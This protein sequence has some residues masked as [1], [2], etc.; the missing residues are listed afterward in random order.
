MTDIAN[1]PSPSS[2][3]VG[4]AAEL[5]RPT[6]VSGRRKMMVAG[7]VLVVLA[8]AGWAMAGFYGDRLSPL[9]R[10]G[11]RFPDLSARETD[12]A[13]EEELTS[14][15][16]ALTRRYTDEGLLIEAT[17]NTQ[18]LFA[19]L[20]RYQ[21]TRQPSAKADSLFERTQRVHEMDRYIVFTL[22][23]GGDAFALEDLRPDE[24]IRLRTPSGREVST[25][26]WTEVPTS[27]PDHS[28]IG[29]LH[30][31][32]VTSDGQPLIAEGDAWLEM[33][34]VALGTDEQVLRWELPIVYPSPPSAAKPAEG[35]R[36]AERHSP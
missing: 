34:L 13:I 28:W 10:T 36:V 25:S 33:V 26:T 20:S 6:G 14:V 22:V 2:N 19:A 3:V 32:R 27:M 21:A 24:M 8:L 35:E 15:T 9:P 11:D 23:L 12:L 29:I 31:P 5:K 1:A 17:Y 4:T 16:D 30:F 7:T 18:E